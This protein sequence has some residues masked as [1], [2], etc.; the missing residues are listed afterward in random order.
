MLQIV[1]PRRN[2]VASIDVSNIVYVHP[3]VED[4]TITIVLPD[5]SE[6]VFKA[7][8]HQLLVL[9]IAALKVAMSKGTYVHKYND[10]Y[11]CKVWS[12]ACYVIYMGVH[13]FGFFE[14]K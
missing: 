8:S 12:S 13:R 14:D 9:W 10:T 11:V 4:R 3:N 1:N 7:V 6:I 2:K 5:D